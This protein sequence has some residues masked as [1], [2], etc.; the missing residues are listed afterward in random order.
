MKYRTFPYETAVYEEG[1]ETIPYIHYPSLDALGFVSHLFTTRQGGVSEGMFASLNLSSNRGDDKEKVLENYRRVAKV[2]GCE[3]KDFV[4]SDQT[5]TTNIRVV[6][7]EDRGKGIV[8]PQDYQDIDGIITNTKGLALGT[9][10]ADC[11]PLFFAD[12]VTKAVGVSHSG[13]KGTVGRMGAKTLEAMERAFGTNPKDVICCVGPSI[14]VDCYEVSEDVAE[15]FIKAFHVKEIPSYEGKAD[16]CKHILYQKNAEKYQLDLHAANEK[17]LLD[18]GI[19]P[20]HL[21]MP[22]M[23]T[24]CNPE[25]LFS[26]RASLGKR[27]NLGAFIMIR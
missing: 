8:K 2:L 20:E 22:G 6:T 4:F 21:S 10:Y 17:V 14:C 26:H 19:L 3:N 11:V 7:E 1:G 18:A 9:F 5:H 23:C 16:S 25:Q 12:P 15:Q 24:C 27:G 13:W